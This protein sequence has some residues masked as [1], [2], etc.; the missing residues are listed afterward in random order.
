LKRADGGI[1]PREDNIERE[2]G[3]E[4]GQLAKYYRGI[5]EK[6]REGDE[7]EGREQAREKAIDSQFI[8]PFSTKD[9]YA[10]M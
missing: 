7:P 6:I 1:G 2:R 4:K 5:E 9:T 3:K 10:Y 8:P